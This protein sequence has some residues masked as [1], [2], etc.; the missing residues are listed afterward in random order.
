MQIEGGLLRKVAGYGPVQGSLIGTENSLVR[1]SVHGRALIDRETIHVH[2][3]LAARRITLE[4][5]PNSM[6][7]ERW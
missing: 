4:A 1:N 5:A 2:D 7:I 6:V 3:Y